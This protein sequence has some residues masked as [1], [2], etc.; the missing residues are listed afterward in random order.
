MDGLRSPAGGARGWPAVG[1]AQRLGIA[2]GIWLALGSLGFA[3]TFRAGPFDFTVKGTADLGYESNVDSAYP[4][5]EDPLYDKSDFYWMPGLALQSSAARIRPNTTFNL[6]GTCEYQDY[7]KR[8]DKD[9]EL[10]D[11]SADFRTVFPRLTLH[12]NGIATRTADAEQDAYRPGGSV[13]D[14][15]QTVEGSFSAN[16]NFKKLRLEGDFDYSQERHDKEIYQTD[17]QDETVVS[18]GAYLDLFTWGSMF[19]TWKNDVITYQKVDKETDETTQNAGFSG[20]VPKIVH[21]HL[22]Y[23]V[24]AEHKDSKTNGEQ[25]EEPKWEPT[26]S[27]GAQDSLAFTKTVLLSASA[28]WENKVEDDEV[29]FRYDAELSQQLTPS[30]RHAATYSREPQDTFGSNADTETTTF[31]YAFDAKD[32]IIRGLGASFSATYKLEKP[33]DE[34]DAETEKTTTYNASVTHVRQISKRL[35][36]SLT[37]AYS[38]ENSNLHHDGAK[39]EHLAIY[40]FTYDF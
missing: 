13:R 4:E 21:P 14:P 9:S 36:R 24:G 17:D 22:T 3:Q 5:D 38:W 28:D 40:G 12:G 37:Y 39:E 11:F 33:L 23:S 10:Y 7:F 19:Y 6:A 34:E 8:N 20:T 18:A 2:A 27:V 32:V 26:Y 31:G 35:S 1:G 25:D 30:L 29:T 16:W 15:M